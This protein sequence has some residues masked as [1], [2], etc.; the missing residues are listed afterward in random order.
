MSFWYPVYGHPL[1]DP[2]AT[3]MLADPWY[4]V[5]GDLVLTADGHPNEPTGIPCFRIA[6]ELVY[7][8]DTGDLPWFEVAGSLIYALESHPM[9]WNRP[10]WYQVR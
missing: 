7:P 3:G 1:F 10:P 6:D 2:T 5:D 4:R 8:I 9:G